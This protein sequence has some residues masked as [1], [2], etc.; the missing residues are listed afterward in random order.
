MIETKLVVQNPHGL[1]ARP[2]TEFV[3]IAQTFQADITLEKDGKSGNGKSLIGVMSLGISQGAEIT[4][5]AD[6]TDEV[7]AVQALR[8][9]V[10]PNQT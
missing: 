2:A 8:E 10:E 7:A 6:G 1:H 5:L 9:L 4:L 3:Q